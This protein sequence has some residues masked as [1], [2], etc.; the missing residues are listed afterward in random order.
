MC[1]EYIFYCECVCVRVEREES[2][3]QVKGK[4][5]EHRQLLSKP[6]QR[7]IW[8]T[9]IPHTRTDI[10]Q[11]GMR[12]TDRQKTTDERTEAHY[13]NRMK[14]I[15]KVWEEKRSSEL[16]HWIST[17]WFSTI[18]IISVRSS[19][20]SSSSRGLRCQLQSRFADRHRNDHRRTTTGSRQQWRCT[21]TGI[22]TWC[23]LWLEWRRY[24]RW[25]QWS[26][27]GWIT[28]KVSGWRKKWC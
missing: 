13:K 16:V 14:L 28:E 18:I 17:R 9:S 2:L 12:E 19:G 10:D 27:S 5:E 22:R 3:I 25:R 11:C 7:S 24:D 1:N 15:Y 23:Q 6:K 21:W 20:S 8:R 26:D 4:R